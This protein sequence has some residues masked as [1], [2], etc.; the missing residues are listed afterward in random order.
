MADTGLRGEM[1]DAIETMVAEAFVDRGLV[2]QVAPDE[3]VLGIVGL[4][5][6]V[7]FGKSRFLQGRI[8]VVVDI[9]D[10]DHGIAARDQLGGGME[11]DEAG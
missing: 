8:V 6:A 10:A 4:G 2:G 11:A 1:D 3:G 5:D 9:V 7:E